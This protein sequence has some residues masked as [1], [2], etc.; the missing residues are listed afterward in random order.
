MYRGYVARQ[1]AE[2]ANYRSQTVHGRLHGAAIATAG[3]LFIAYYPSLPPNS[4]PA[5]TTPLPHGHQSQPLMAAG[6]T[7][8][9]FIVFLLRIPSFY[10][11]GGSC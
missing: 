3:P 10:S 7:F 4:P 11:S 9:F 2:A 8:S 6:T 1:M 5:S